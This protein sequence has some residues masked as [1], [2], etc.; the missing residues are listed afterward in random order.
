MQ[1]GTFIG[2]TPPYMAPEQFKGYI[3]KESD[4]Y[5]LGCLAYELFT[6]KPPFSAPDFVSMGYKHAT[7]RPVA[8]TYLNPS[9]PLSLEQIVLKA[10]A[11]QRSERYPDIIAFITALSS[12]S[13]PAQHAITLQGYA[14]PTTPPSQPRLQT[15]N[16]QQVE[17]YVPPQNQ[18]FTNVQP[19]DQIRLVGSVSSPSTPKTQTSHVPRWKQFLR[20]SF[21]WLE[22]LLVLR[23]LLRLLGANQDSGFVTFLYNLSHVFVGIFNGIFNDQAIGTSHVIETS[24]TMAMIF[25][26]LL[27]LIVW[28]LPI[29]N[30]LSRIH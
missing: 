14:I 23:F 28:R 19:P 8:L 16:F 24:T 27:F 6:G 11:K 1:N 26:G 29:R 15:Y 10:L 17:R 25:Y 12:Y 7:E 21:I 30:I 2:G 18:I 4:Q 9:L 3:S 5:A 13:F 20:V 22:I